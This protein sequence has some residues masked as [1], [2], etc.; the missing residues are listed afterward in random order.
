MKRDC[1]G[2]GAMLIACV[3]VIQ[4]MV[5]G[6][7]IAS[8]T[9]SGRIV[10]E[11]ENRVV[12]AIPVEG[13][14]VMELQYTQSL[15]GGTQ[16]ERYEVTKNIFQL[17]EMVFPNHDSLQYYDQ[18]IADDLTF[19]DD[20]RIVLQK[21]NLTKLREIDFRNPRFSNLVLKIDQQQYNLSSLAP[22]GEVIT[23]TAIGQ[24]NPKESRR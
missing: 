13:Q 15:Y 5:A 24:P 10:V 16:V 14:P 9:P 17:K 7:V 21:A 2:T 22:R 11:V 4:L 6:A 1:R 3:V 23:L 12:N 8:R 18:A 19:L 20:G